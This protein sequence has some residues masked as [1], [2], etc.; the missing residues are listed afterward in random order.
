MRQGIETPDNFMLLVV[1]ESLEAHTEGFAKSEA[2]KQFGGL[3][4][5]FFAGRPTMDHYR[6]P[7]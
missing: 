5:P 4:A 2:I 6:Q 7:L 3:L 1:W